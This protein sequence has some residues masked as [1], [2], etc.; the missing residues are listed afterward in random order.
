MTVEYSTQRTYNTHLLWLQETAAVCFPLLLNKSSLKCVCEVN[1]LFFLSFRFAFLWSPSNRYG[2]RSRVSNK[3]FHLLAI[4]KQRNYQNVNMHS[5][6]NPLVWPFPLHML[7]RTTPSI[8]LYR[9]PNDADGKEIS[10]VRTCITCSRLFSLLFRFILRRIM[11]LT[12]KNIPLYTP[13]DVKSKWR[14]SPALGHIHCFARPPPLCTHTH[15]Q[16]ACLLPTA[17]APNCI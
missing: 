14:L 17:T 16:H 5:P 4:K 12:S 11:V 7:L 13:L 8:P 6:L 2:M 3:T 1:V 15:T 9:T 10:G